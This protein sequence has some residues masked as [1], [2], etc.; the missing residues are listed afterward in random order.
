VQ[1]PEPLDESRPL[2]FRPGESP[3][4]I[5]GV[6]YRG[7]LEYVTEFVDGGVEEMLRG[8]RDPALVEFFQQKFLPSTFYDIIPLIVA[9]YVCARQTRKSFSEFVRIRSRY[10]A[11]RDVGGVYRVLIKL[12]SPMHVIERLSA[13]QSQYLSF[14]EGEVEVLGDKRV[15]LT[16][17]KLPHALASWTGTVLEANIDVLL[18]RAGARNVLARPLPLVADGQVHG[19]AAVKWQCD[20]TWQ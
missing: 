1:Q 10:Q 2:P 14:A 19:V 6:A 13:L 8:F 18:T 11:E 12:V 4:K 5:K 9:G 15:L 7:H 17:P 20:I 3:F 16:R